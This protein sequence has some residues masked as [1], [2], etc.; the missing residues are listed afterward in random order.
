MPAALAFKTTDGHWIQHLGVDTGTHLPKLL[1]C[2]GHLQRYGATLKIALGA[3]SALA[4]GIYR[5]AAGQHI[6]EA[7]RAVTEMANGVILDVMEG[8]TLEEFT[9]WADET[10]WAFWSQILT[11]EEARVYP[12]TTALGL[13]SEAEVGKAPFNI[14][15]HEGTIRARL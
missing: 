15:Q 9:A 1:G 12:N 6:L 10:G 5:Y 4:A 7:I 2:L 13:I 11:V 8:M 3:P 14:R